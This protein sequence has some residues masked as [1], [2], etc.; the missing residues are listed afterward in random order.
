LEN[1]DHGDSVQ[2]KRQRKKRLD[3]VRRAKGASR[4]PIPLQTSNV[5]GDLG[6]D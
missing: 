5:G 6:G 4:Q 2:P 1:S 3:M